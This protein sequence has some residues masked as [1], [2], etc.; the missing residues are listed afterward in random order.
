MKRI[1]LAALLTTATATSALAA[2]LD[3]SGQNVLAIFDDPNTLQFSV[4]HVMPDVTG[5]DPTRAAYDVFG[6]YTQV[7]A[8]Y[9]N[10]IN[11]QLSYAVIYDQPFG[12]DLN[13]NGDPTANLLAGTKA[14]ITSQALTFAL[15][16]QY[17]QRVSAFAGIRAQ[18]VTGDVSLNGG[19]YAQAFSG[20]DGGRLITAAG[21][22]PVTDVDPF[23]VGGGYR[24]DV[25]SSWGVGYTF[26]AAYEIPEIALRLAVTYHSE[27][28]HDTTV[29]E[30]SGPTTIGNSDLSYQTPQSI[31]IDFQTGINERTLLLAGMRWTDWDDFKLAPPVLDNN[32]ASI[33]AEYRY[34]LGVARRFNEDFVGLANLT[35]EKDLG[36][37][38]G[39]PLGPTEGVIGLSIGGRY[40]SGNMNI[41]GG[42]S[43]SVLG[44]A[45]AA[46]GGNNIASF[47]NNSATAIGLRFNYTF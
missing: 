4:S 19:G 10:E 38:G 36:R 11:D 7:F 46:I 23:L 27:V 25:Q 3:R 5:T 12:L 21:G 22:T 39:S 17:N 26:G 24:A 32:L 1:A 42:V 6:S 37:S 41:S 45:N 34:T 18:E 15:K 35:Y 40:T 33:N 13:Y 14:D 43:Y 44:D 47:T 2:G 29:I 9:A 16:Y 8:S 20:S 28:T 31:N 30:T